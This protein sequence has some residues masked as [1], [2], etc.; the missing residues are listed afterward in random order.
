MMEHEV[1]DARSSIAARCVRSIDSE[2]RF[3]EN[4]NLRSFMFG[5]DLPASEIF[6]RD[7]LID[8]A[9]RQ[10]DKP[11]FGYCSSGAVGVSDRWEKGVG[12]GR[13]LADTLAD[14][15][16]NDSLVMLKHVEQDP[17]LGPAVTVLL[18]RMVEL[19]GV[20]MRDDVIVGR[21]TIL[22]ASPRRITAYHID[23]DTNFLF[24]IA[25]DKIFRVFDQ[26]DR[27]LVTDNELE[28]FYAGDANGA[29]F[30]DTRQGDAITYDFRG[31]RGVHI[32]SMA[33]HWAQNGDTVSVALSLN[34]DLRSV[35]NS[36]R[37]YAINRRLRNF[38]LDP[39]PPGR[40]AWRDHMK[41]TTAN[42]AAMLR[43]VSG[44]SR[45]PQLLGWVPPTTG[46]RL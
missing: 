24:Q 26:T 13:T 14:I 22:V 20:R 3:S 46:S 27:T 23:A 4:Y 9:V 28:N 40:S 18:S 12:R 41:L 44:R 7:S 1:I 30:K 5:H 31:G 15:E 38:G 43:Q 33:P 34:Y 21:A 2:D 11:G 10:G 29:V 36:G 37:V 19:A 32:P 16:H 8:V 6:N 25:G 42:A 45:P 17:V 35:R 39:V